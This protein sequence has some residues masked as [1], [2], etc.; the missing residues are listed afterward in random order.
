[1][2]MPQPNNDEVMSGC[3]GCLMCF[4]ALVD[5]AIV[6]GVLCLFGIDDL[7]YYHPQADGINPGLFWA[8]LIA[9]Y[10]AVLFTSFWGLYYITKPKK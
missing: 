2:I 3:V 7:D 5:V 8:G 1:M 6:Q 10:M 4:V 9:F